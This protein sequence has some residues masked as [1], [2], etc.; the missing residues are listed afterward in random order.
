MTI[1]ANLIPGSIPSSAIPLHIYNLPQHL[2]AQPQLVRLACQSCLITLVTSSKP[3]VS[4]G[5]V[6][7]FARA[8]VEDEFYKR[9]SSYGVNP[10]F[11]RAVN[12]LTFLINHAT[13][14]SINAFKDSGYNE[15]KEIDM[16]DNHKDIQKY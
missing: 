4:D 9:N 7:G 15:G 6:K 8:F 5:T 3:G 2:Q 10:P 12:I 1:H 11:R 16:F 14:K 13:R